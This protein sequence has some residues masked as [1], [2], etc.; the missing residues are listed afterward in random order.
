MVL[1]YPPASEASREEAKNLFDLSS[2]PNKQKINK[3]LQD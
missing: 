1:V 2:T 3:N